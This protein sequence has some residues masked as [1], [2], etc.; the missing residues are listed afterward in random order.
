MST[1]KR[2][3]IQLLSTHFSTPA[4]NRNEHVSAPK[5]SRQTEICSKKR[6]KKPMQKM[7]DTLLS[8]E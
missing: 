4:V 2:N 1:H 7:C 5:N 6:L 8:P 3:Y